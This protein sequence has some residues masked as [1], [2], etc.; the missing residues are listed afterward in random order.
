MWKRPQSVYNIR[1]H[2][3]NPCYQKLHGAI[4]G[5]CPL[6][7]LDPPLVPN[8]VVLGQTVHAL[9]AY[10][11]RMAGKI[12]PLASCLSKLLERAQ[13]GYLMIFSHTTLYLLRRRCWGDFQLETNSTFCHMQHFTL[14]FHLQKQCLSMLMKR[15]S[16]NISSAL[17]ILLPH[18]CHTTY[19]NKSTIE[20]KLERLAL[21]MKGFC[22]IYIYVIYMYCTTTLNLMLT[23]RLLL[24]SVF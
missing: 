17:Q 23:C 15:S 3:K 21:R 4:G 24:F 11:W 16:I 14:H 20:L 9:T 10:V 13:I 19:A 6:R 1:L 5:G 18:V 22:C 7:P 8:L 2:T 12:G